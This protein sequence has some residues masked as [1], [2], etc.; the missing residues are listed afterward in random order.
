M[1]VVGCG[2]GNGIEIRPLSFEH[3]PKVAIPLGSRP[4]EVG[5]FS[6]LV[7]HVAHESDVLARDAN[8]VVVSHA[9]HADARH[10]E[11]IARRPVPAAQHVRWN[12][13]EGIRARAGLGEFGDETAT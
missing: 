12:D 13:R 7:V 4:L 2:H 10:V 5:T 8:D 1:H 9:S 3:L 6:R 11:C